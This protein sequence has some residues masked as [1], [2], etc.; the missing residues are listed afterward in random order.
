MSVFFHVAVIFLNVNTFLWAVHINSLCELQ[1]RSSNNNNVQN[2]TERLFH[3][4]CSTHECD[5]SCVKDNVL[6]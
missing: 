1:G 3:L 6:M 5:L 2:D 4:Q